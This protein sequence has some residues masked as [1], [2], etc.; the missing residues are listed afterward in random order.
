MKDPSVFAIW[1]PVKTSCLYTDASAIGLGCFLTQLAE[2]NKTEVVIAFGSVALT[3]A[4]RKYQITRSEA[5]AFIWSLGHFHAYLCARPFLWKTDHR[6]LKYIFDASRSQV[7]VLARYK[8]IAD[9]YKFCPVWISG[10]TM[11]ADVFSRLCVVPTGKIAMTNREM[12]MA[13][14]DL[15][16]IADINGRRQLNNSTAD[17]LFSNVEAVAE[18]D[19]DESDPDLNP[20]DQPLHEDED[21]IRG[22]LAI[23]V[24]SFSAHDLFSIR[25]FSHVRQYL[26]DKSIPDGADRKLRKSIVKSASHCFLHDGKLFRKRRGIIREACD[27][28]QLRRAALKESHEGTAHRGVENSLNYLAS[29]YW[30]PQMEKFVCRYMAQCARCQQFARAIPNDFP[31]YAFSISDIL[32]HWNVDFAGPFPEDKFG[33]KYVCVGIEQ[34]S[35]WAEIRCSATNTAADAANFI[36][37]DIVCRF[38]LPKSIHSDNGPHFANE[39]IERLTQILSIRHKFSTPYYPQ[40]NGRVERLIG[41]LKTMMSKAVEDT[42]RDDSDGT[43]NWQPAIYT[44]LYVYRSSPHHATGV[45]PAYL[46]YGE[47]VAL[48][49]LHKH[50]APATPRDQVTHKNQ[51]AERLAYIREAIPGLRGS[52]HQFARTKEG[53]KVLVRPARYAVG[54]HVLIRN[55]NLGYVG[56]GSAFGS[57]YIGPY[58]IRSIGDKGAY[59]IATLPKDGKHGRLLKNPINWS[60]LRKFVPEGDDEFFVTENVEVVD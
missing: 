14:L 33:F 2:D 50:Q 46:L 30:F 10:S 55:P 44:A 11:I 51:L 18:T 45:S 4:Q 43:V 17:F 5:L 22:K 27:S 29:R 32:S 58:E 34:V 3:S 25:A 7:P 38:G 60:R 26:I 52:H 23:D 57:P 19:D 39:V 16:K 54:D 53:R 13:D 56:H 49:F 36:Y 31:N 20:H 42:D 47:N 48:P 21:S 59:R 15:S 37:H 28:F 35:R 12:V 1:S 8:L 6:A 40:S 41:T 9:E 24:P